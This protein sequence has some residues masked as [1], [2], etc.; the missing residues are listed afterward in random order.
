MLRL[1]KVQL[2]PKH[3]P[4]YFESKRQA[5]HERDKL[6]EEHDRDIPVMRGPDHWKGESYGVVQ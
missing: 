5:K 6:A 2:S 4:Q 1:F 3:D